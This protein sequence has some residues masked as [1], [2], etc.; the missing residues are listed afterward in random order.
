MRYNPYEDSKRL[1]QQILVNDELGLKPSQTAKN[2]GV[3]RQRVAY[4]LA[5]H[6]R[7]R[8]KLPKRGSIPMCVVCRKKPV[9]PYS[10]TSAP[11]RGAYSYSTRPWRAPEASWQ[12][13]REDHASQLGREDTPRDHACCQG[14]AYTSKDGRSL[15]A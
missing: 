5:K 13:E 1:E 2:L 12:P 14:E 10:S 4:F 3:S 7:S 6:G 9:V 15:Y 8:P 11:T